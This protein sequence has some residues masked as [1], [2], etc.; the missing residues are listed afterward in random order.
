MNL[1][2]VW[3]YRENGAAAA[4]RLCRPVE[5]DHD[6]VRWSGLGRGGR[7]LV[8]EAPDPLIGGVREFFRKMR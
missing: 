2:S 6:V 7:F 4:P 5:R 8:M 1:Q 3:I